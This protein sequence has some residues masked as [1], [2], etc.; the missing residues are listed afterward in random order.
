MIFFILLLP[1]LAF[2]ST[3][4][5]VGLYSDFIWR[6]T[7]FTENRPA[8]QGELDSESKNGYFL[9]GFISNAEF[10][11]PALDK[12]ATVTSEVDVTIGK[13]WYGDQWDIQAYYSQ[14]YFPGAKVFNTDEWNIQGHYKHFFLELSLMDDYF[15]YHSRYTYVRVGFDWIYKNS[16][17]GALYLGLNA[18]D[19]AKGNIKT[20]EGYETLNGAGNPNYT[21]LFFVNKKVLKNNHAAELAINWTDRQEYSV[22][23][24]MIQKDWAKDFVIIISYVIPFEL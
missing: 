9:A 14:F 2:S 23:E 6:G 18:F 4:A 13:R 17:T 1:L 16:L 7:T 19:R 8:I 11:D 21:D 24:G 5:E 22:S 15:G 20:R 3:D 10:S 12:N